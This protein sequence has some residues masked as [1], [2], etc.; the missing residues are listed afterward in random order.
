MRNGCAWVLVI[1]AAC[2]ESEGG[3]PELPVHPI[4][5][6]YTLLWEGE[7]LTYLDRDIEMPI[8][9]ASY[10]CPEF[11]TAYRLTAERLPPPPGLSEY[12]S[13]VE[14]RFWLDPG[15]AIKI[16]GSLVHVDEVSGVATI[17]VGARGDESG[18]RE[19]FVL[20][21]VPPST[22]WTATLV[23]TQGNLQLS[24]RLTATAVAN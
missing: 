24:R 21:Q 6:E 14:L 10:R 15:T 7:T 23:W 16:E 8:S 17:S 1:A 20:R 22:G 3:P 2:T 18:V 19:A 9:C 11:C 4:A 12:W 13:P 5:A